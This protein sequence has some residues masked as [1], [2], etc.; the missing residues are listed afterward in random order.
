MTYKNDNKP[1]WKGIKDF[2][3]EWFTNHMQ[4]ATYDAVKK[5]GLE[6]DENGNAI[7]CQ[8]DAFRHAY[9][10]C[11][12]A[13]RAGEK[14]AKQLGDE[15]EHGRNPDIDKSANMDLWN[16][17]IGRE[18]AREVKQEYG[19]ELYLYDP[20]LLQCI[21]TQKII[22]R[23]DKGELITNPK[24]DKRKY[25]NMEKERLKDDD[26]VF[27]EGE[28]YDDLDEDERSRFSVHYANYLNK[29]QKGMP[30]KEEFDKKVLSGDLIYVHN[31][32][33]SDGTKVNGYY[34]RRIKY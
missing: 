16:N 14:R 13:Y 8:A 11:W 21:V 28:Y 25:S 10:Q 27:Y 18:I 4:K 1:T 5:Y 7:D 9:M 22:A 23:I 31:Y 20:G 15:H 6:L 17:Q 26:R 19:N 24:E 29:H 32:E 30:S 34:R 33:R 3:E 2:P 12:L